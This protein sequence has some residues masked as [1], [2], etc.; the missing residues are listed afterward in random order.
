[1][2]EKKL[3]QLLID[4]GIPYQ[5]R[6]LSVL[7]N[8]R[9]FQGIPEWSFTHP[10]TNGAQLGKHSS[11]DILGLQL[12]S[13]GYFK[14]ASYMAIEC[15]RADPST[16][17][18]VFTR[19]IEEQRPVPTFVAKTIRNSI[20]GDWEDYIIHNASFPALGY[21][22]VENLD[23]CIRGIEVNE[24][25][26]ATNRNSEEKIYKALLQANH[27]S[28]A[29]MIQHPKHIESLEMPLDTNILLFFP[30]VVTTANL[31]IAE[32]DPTSINI[33]EGEISVQNIQYTK[34]EWL[35][36]E[37]STPD[38]LKQSSG[39][40]QKELDIE[41]TTTFIV[42]APYWEEFLSNFNIR[43]VT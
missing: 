10:R 11:V 22:S 3:T 25:F 27:A 42:G 6:C 9:Y 39:G 35:T 23:Y 34:K 1:M 4:Y 32:Y 15:K 24:R 12:R 2:D 41:R 33:S 30:V 17:N 26:D 20:G 18:W 31:F 37:F 21:G 38:Y 7:R 13:N 36:F 43:P 16:K 14:G 29:L 40:P 5:D 28:N 19:D 8:D